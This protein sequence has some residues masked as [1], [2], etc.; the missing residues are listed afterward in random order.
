MLFET[1]EEGQTLAVVDTVLDSEQLQAELDIA[2]AEVHHLQAQLAVTRDQF[3]A[4]SANLETDRVAV[5]RGFAVDVENARLRILE[6]MTQLETDRLRLRDLEA[7]VQIATALVEKDAISPYEMQKAQAQHDVVAKQIEENQSVLHQATK[8]F[9]EAR[10][11]RDEF[12]K[13]QLRHPSVDNALEVIRRAALVQQQ[14]VEALLARRLPLE[15]KCPFDGLVSQ[16]WHRAGEAVQVGEAILTLTR[17]RPTEIM[18]YAGQDQLGSVRQNMKVEL[19]KSNPP[20]QVAV[21]QVAYVGPVMELMPERLW[22]N[23]NIPQYG[24]PVMIRI[25]PGMQLVGGEMVGVRGL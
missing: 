7:E 24:L 20:E 9:L 2:A 17:S 16:V 10:R 11:R 22:Q 15:L 21:S 12:A 25:P 14:R 5:I 3:L 23:P 1:V 18:A 19:V 13:R 4:E 6:L 8:D